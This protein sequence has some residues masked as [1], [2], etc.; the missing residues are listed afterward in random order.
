MDGW[1]GKC[2][3]NGFCAHAETNPCA[4]HGCDGKKCGDVCL[5]EGDIMGFCD[6]HLNCDYFKKPCGI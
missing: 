1:D 6:K 3:G 5:R 2:D 4:V